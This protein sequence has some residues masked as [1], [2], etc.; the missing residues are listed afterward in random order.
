M[1]LVYDG[2]YAEQLGY[3]H[4]GYAAQVL[5]D[6]EL[7]AIWTPDFTAYAAACACG[8]VGHRHAP[9]NEGETAACAEWD[10]DH[11]QPMIATAAREG[12]PAW[13]ART[14]SAATEIAADLADG[15]IA[16]AGEVMTR[17]VADVTS[18]ARTL[19]RLVEERATC[20]TGER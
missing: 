3:E 8:W 12:W 19:E 10:R 9:T 15:R 7:T 5:P 6:G 13:A 17:L 14:A 2:A 1:G 16:L 20:V 11:L 4:E 18:W